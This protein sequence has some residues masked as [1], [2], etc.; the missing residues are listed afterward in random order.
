MG[1]RT[2]ELLGKPLP[3]RFNIV[4]TRNSEYIASGCRIARTLQEALSAAEDYATNTGCDEGMI[5]GGGKVYAEAMDRWDRLYLTLVEGQFGGNTYFP[6]RELLQ[7]KWRP[8]CARKCIPRKKRIRTSTPS[9]SSNGLGRRYLLL[10]Q[11]R[12]TPRR[13]WRGWI[14][15]RS[16]RGTFP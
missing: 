4:L 14:S 12:R 10:L 6:V 8:V 16:W 2:F 9:T 15:L 11:G 7:Q 13:P 1:R 3:G 5:I